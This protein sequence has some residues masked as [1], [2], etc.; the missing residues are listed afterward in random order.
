MAGE[1]QCRPN[2]TSS[3][4]IDGKKIIRLCVVV[5]KDAQELTLFIGT[6]PPKT[7]KVNGKIYNELKD[8]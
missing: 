2:I 6:Y 8:W 7:F 3:G 4:I 1:R 5:P